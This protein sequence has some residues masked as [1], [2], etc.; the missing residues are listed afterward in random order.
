MGI[1]SHPVVKP[2]FSLPIRVRGFRESIAAFPEG[3]SGFPDRGPIGCLLIAIAV[4]SPG[5]ERAN[6]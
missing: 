5:T 2:E 3:A 1:G 4:L 6:G